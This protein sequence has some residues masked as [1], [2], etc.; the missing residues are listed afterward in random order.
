MQRW[1]QEIIQGVGLGALVA[2]VGACLVTPIDTTGGESESESEE[3]GEEESTSED[4]DTTNNPT[5]NPTS[6]THDSDAETAGTT[7][8]ST[9]PDPT[10]TTSVPGVCGDG[11]VDRDEACD[12]GI[13]DGSYGG[14]MA[15]C[16]A[17]G[18]MCGDGNV[19]EGREVCDD[20]VNDGSYGGCADGCAALG[21]FCGDGTMD[22]GEEEC[23]DGNGV[24]DDECSNE[25]NPAICGDG[26]VQGGIGEV[27]D[28]GVNDGGYGSCVADCTASGPK[29]GDGNV[30]IDFESC[31]DNNM[32]SQD[33][34][35]GDCQVPQNCAQIL[36]FDPAS[37]D[38]V[39]KLA[40][41]DTEWTAYCDMMTD[42]GGW[43]LAAKVD[44]VNSW[45]YTNVRWTDTSLLSPTMSDYDHVPA[46]LATW[47]VV[48]F[49]QIH[50][51]MEPFVAN[52][53]ELPAPTYITLDAPAASL[54]ALFNG[55]FVATTA[56]KATW[57]TLLPNTTLEANCDQEG[58][59][60]Q[61]TNGGAQK[62]RLGIV[63]STEMDCDTP[64]S[65]IGVGYSGFVSNCMNNPFSS[66][67]NLNCATNPVAKNRGFAWIFVR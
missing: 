18:P 8:E 25:C 20:G 27:C 42:G 34:C 41:E 45:Q 3:E 39:Y 67:G 44:P 66:V 56:T 1:K 14:C 62:V 59:N 35:L 6:T 64:D 19:D 4:E 28:D 24:N 53:P 60:N 63:S 12:D 5:N 29:C 65:V 58:I 54:N 21:P 38:G 16:S 48:P 50:L 32:D 11:N 51:G 26:I 36:A 47:N 17:P 46:K 55:E 15:D 10:D 31:D 7:T 23:D 52:N 13:N 33:G 2:C 22:D 37:P 40:V 43:T 61:A 9:G 57:S 49:T 30:D